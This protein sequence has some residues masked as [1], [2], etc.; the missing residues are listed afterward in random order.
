MPTIINT[1]WQ[2]DH[3]PTETDAEHQE[4]KEKNLENRL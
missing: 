4:E 2:F 1:N 3:T